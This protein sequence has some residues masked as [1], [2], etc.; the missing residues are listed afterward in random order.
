LLQNSRRMAA[1]NAVSIL[2]LS[3]HERKFNFACWYIIATGFYVIEIKDCSSL[4]ENISRRISYAYW[5]LYEMIRM[6]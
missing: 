1:T 4:H 5:K 6:W 3:S 2:L